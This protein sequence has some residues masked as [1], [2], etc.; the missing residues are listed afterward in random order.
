MHAYLNLRAMRLTLLGFAAGLPIVLVFG[1]LSFWLRDAQIDRSTIGFVGWVALAYAFKF[2]WS[3]LVDSLGL[4]QLTRSL[5]RRK[6]WLLAAQMAVVAGLVG[7][8]S[9]TH[10]TLP[11]IYS[12]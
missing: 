3:P 1:T 8:V 10:L 5:G 2:V 9:Y 12:V 6:G 11:T 4:G 7:T